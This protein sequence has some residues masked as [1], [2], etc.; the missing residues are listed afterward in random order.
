M[1]DVPVVK[2]IISGGQTGADRAALDFALNHGFEIKGFCPQGRRA[3]DGPLDQR[4]PL[5]E[6]ES[7]SY[8]ERTRKNV[9]LADATVIFNGLPHYSPGTKAAVKH[10]SLRD[11]PFKVLTN[12]PD[13]EKD[14]AELI[15]W[16]NQIQPQSLNIAGNAEEK[17]PGIYRHVIKVLSTVF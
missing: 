17:R 4:Y 11:K 8:P 7:S 9:M 3:E 10:A 6:T 1:R 12:Y 15:N 13:V 2:I 16:I 5:V 14:A